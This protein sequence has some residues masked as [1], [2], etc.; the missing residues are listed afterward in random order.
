M[1][2][3]VFSPENQLIKNIKLI[4]GYDSIENFSIQYSLLI[5]KIS[6]SSHTGLDTKHI[7]FENLDYLEELVIGDD[8]FNTKNVSGGREIWKMDGTLF[9]YEDVSFTLKNLS[10]LNKVVIG[11]GSFQTTTQFTI[12]SK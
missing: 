11:A 7:R 8:C 2:L 10:R 4:P 3:N 9:K 5:E 6:I 12:Q 1:Q